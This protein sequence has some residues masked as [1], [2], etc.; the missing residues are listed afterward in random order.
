MLCGKGYLRG[1]RRYQA[2]ECSW[3]QLY[4][5]G[6]Y[7]ERY[8]HAKR[9]WRN[10]RPE[11]LAD[12]GRRSGDYDFLHHQNYVYDTALVSTAVPYGI[13]GF[14]TVKKGG[15]AAIYRVGQA[16][17]GGWTNGTVFQNSVGSKVAGWFWNSDCW[18]SCCSRHRCVDRSLDLF[19]INE[20]GPL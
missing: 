16:T 17:V 2:V 15:D 12:P 1:A 4:R 7:R 5:Y 19:T 8:R 18:R 20:L 14:I 13:K 9:R 3:R 6:D 10:T 11:S